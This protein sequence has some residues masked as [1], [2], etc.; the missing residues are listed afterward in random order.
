MPRCTLAIAIEGEAVGLG[1]LLAWIFGGRAYKSINGKTNPKA[2][3]EI[4]EGKG[5]DPATS[6]RSF[7]AAKNQTTNAGQNQSTL[8]VKFHGCAT[9]I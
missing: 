8:R 1:T 5:T 4:G 9:A 6:L 3:V 2:P 7:T